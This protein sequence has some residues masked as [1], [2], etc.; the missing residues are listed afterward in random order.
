VSLRQKLILDMQQ[1]MRARDTTRLETVRL[2]RAEIQRREVDERTELDD[3]GVL[4]VIQKMIKQGRDSIVQFEKG[5]RIDLV[6]KEIAA[7][8]VLK[9]YL[10]KAFSK[11][12]VATLISKALAE[13]GA[14]SV[15]DMGK[16]MG[17]LKP[18]L[19]GRAD[20]ALVSSAVL[21]KLA[22]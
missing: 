1:A 13:T 20:I 19:Q 6:D 9:T 10:P 15:R 4:S 8:E 16:V 21:E 18:K 17:W 7:L 14:E 5:G 2:L 11:D 22:N 3:D 12:K